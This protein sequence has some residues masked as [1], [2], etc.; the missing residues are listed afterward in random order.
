M[1][2]E[3]I[4]RK[5]EDKGKGLSRNK[6]RIQRAYLTDLSSYSPTIN[7]KLVTLRSSISRIPFVKCNNRKAFQLLEPL[8]IAVTSTKKCISYDSKEGKQLLLDNLAANKHVDPT[9]IIPPIQSQSNCWFNTMFVTF[10]VSDKGRKFF[11]FFRQ[12]MIEGKQ[13]NGQKINPPKLR[14]AFSLLNYAIDAALTGSP[15]A[16][17]LNTNSIIKQ[18]YEAIPDKNPYLVKVD[19]ASNP[20]RYYD[21]IIQYLHNNALKIQ[22]IDVKDDTWTEKIEEKEEPHIIMAEIYDSSGEKAG[23]SGQINHKPLFITTKKGIE[24]KLDSC[25]IRDI[26]QQHF[27]AMITCEEQEMSYD[28]MSYHRLAPMNWTNMLTSTKR[29]QFEGTLNEDGT[30]LKWSFKHGYQI[31]MYYRVK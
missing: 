3:E 31:L 15:I 6:K 25:V 26:E 21:A 16:Y 11:H 8:K 7:E 27:C 23:I 12:L 24:Y 18:I 5:I 17:K 22:L 29:W 1:L 13:A 10:F 4:A 2:S 19:E 20:I 14:N 28:G 9:K 30:P